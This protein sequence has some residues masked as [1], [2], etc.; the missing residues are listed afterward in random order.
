MSRR[1]GLLITILIAILLPWTGLFS[2]ETLPNTLAQL[3]ETLK[4]LQN[5]VKGLQSTVQRLMKEAR[6]NKGAA[7]TA[8]A[9]VTAAIAVRSNWRNALEAYKHGKQLEQQ[10]QYSPA[11]EAYSR[12]IQFDPKSDTAFLHRGNCL[13]QLGE[14]TDAIADFTQS[15]AL[16]PNSSRA[17]L[18]RSC[19]PPRSRWP[20][21]GRSM[22][23]SRWASASR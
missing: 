18:A 21:G 19:S 17:Y 9:P 13:F 7:T 14:Y 1:F 15:L 10:R 5:E 16:Q 6:N 11:I 8:A 3:Q 20:P 2:Q 12:T 4:R 23:S 22:T